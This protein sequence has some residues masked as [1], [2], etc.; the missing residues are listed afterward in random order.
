V[1]WRYVLP[2]TFPPAGRDLLCAPLIEGASASKLR[3]GTCLVSFHRRI[4]SVR[5]CGEFHSSVLLHRAVRAVAVPPQVRSRAQRFSHFTGSGPRPC[6]ARPRALADNIADSKIGPI[7]DTGL[8]ALL[9]PRGARLAVYES[10]RSPA[11]R[12]SAGTE[13]WI[14]RALRANGSSNPRPARA[15]VSLVGFSCSRAADR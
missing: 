2:P 15:R 9:I 3:W 5:C 4:E 14:S 1:G 10:M 11:A 12:R 7:P 13:C 8:S 6:T